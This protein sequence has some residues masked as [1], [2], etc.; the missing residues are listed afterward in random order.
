[1]RIAAAD[2]LGLINASDATEAVSASADMLISGALRIARYMVAHERGLE[3][4]PI[5]TIV[6]AMGRYGGREMTYSSDADVQFVYQGGGDDAHAMAQQVAVQLRQMLQAVSA[7]PPLAIDADLRPEGKNGP[8]VR[9][10]ESCA[11]YYGRWSD[12]WEAQA[13]LRARPCAG[14][15]ELSAAFV[16][17][18][19]GVRY[20]RSLPAGALKQ[21]RTLKA[22]MES[23]R[24]PR[25]IDPRRH[26]KLGPG[27][28]SD[29]EWTVQLVQ[30]QHGANV[31][32]LRTTQTLAALDEAR[33]ARLITA[34]DALTLREAWTMATD[35]RGAMALRGATR[36]SDVLPSDVR[37]LGILAEITGRGL[38]GAELDERYARAARRA[39]AVTE[40]VFFGW[41]QA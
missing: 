40:R 32:G 30:L 22:R 24:L 31:P 12:P 13:L 11:E 15:D 3:D 18:I 23:E 37:E 16:A 19:D 17:M 6:V 41:K 7:Q 14:D 5:E 28:L 34:T 1:V 39:R 35:L 2:A 33:D 27:G 36:D 25:G 9:S 8:L 10:L 4:V 20:P 29:V 38:T 21:M 26:L